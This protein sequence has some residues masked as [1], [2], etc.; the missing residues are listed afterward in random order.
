MNLDDG[1]KQPH[2]RD[3][4]FNGRIQNMVYPD[5]HF[6]VNLRGKQK[7]MRTIL[8]ERELYRDGLKRMCLGC[9]TIKLREQN[10]KTDCCA[11][12]ILELQSDFQ[13]QKGIIQ[14]EIGSRGR[15]VIFY[16]KFIVN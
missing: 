8:L 10:T 15:M 1:G 11:L 9:K 7:G 6:E 14:E 2:M 13:A 3:T 12:K 4:M 16:P 5:D